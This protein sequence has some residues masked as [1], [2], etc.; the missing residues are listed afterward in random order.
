MTGQASIS[1]VETTHAVVHAATRAQVE[2]NPKW[3]N[4]LAR[5]FT[6]LRK[7]ARYYAV[8]EQTILQGFDYAYLVLEDKA[9]DVRAVQPYFV[10]DQDLLQG[11]GRVPLA[12]V[13]TI[14]KA[15]RRFLFMRTLMVGCAAGEGHL[16]SSDPQ[17]GGW[18]AAALHEALDSVAKAHRASMIVFKEFPSA[19]RQAM[20][21]IA[22]NGYTRIP[23][24]P[25]VR[26]NIDYAS[27]DD[28]MNKALSKVTRKGLRRKFRA[29][30]GGPPVEMEV[31]SDLGPYV[32][33]AH[34]LYLNVYNRSKMNFE[35]LTPQYM[36]ELGRQMPEKV[37]Y[38]LWRREG[39]LV[40]MSLCL[41]QGDALYDE[42]LGLDYSIALDIHLYFIT[43]RDVIQWG[44]TNGFKWYCSSALNYDPKLH[45]K[46][47]LAP[48][49]L[50]VTHRSRV[51]NFVLRRV[52]PY[53]EPTRGDPV[54][55]QFKNF[56]DV[57]GGP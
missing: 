6:H 35:K 57:W 40:A 26:L 39:K 33:E 25:M 29:A 32:D 11:A 2:A 14:R 37:R 27:F 46:C 30:E 42:Y 54:L 18:I 43:L 50:Y 19:Y 52:L 31:V 41:L 4:A 24:L 1:C 17:L 47:D 34:A 7:D 9:G 49:D 5:S 23:S 16:E 15:L 38:F 55:K 21:S 36:L 12:I 53:V 51:A 3:R 56:A 13:G 48:L 20:A 45:L 8:V 22:A 44:I 28:Y 10:L